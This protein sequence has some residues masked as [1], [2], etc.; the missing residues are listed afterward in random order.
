[1]KEP[2]ILDFPIPYY[3]QNK[4]HADAY[5]ELCFWYKEF[6]GKDAPEKYSEGNYLKIFEALNNKTLKNKKS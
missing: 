4:E 6:L 2:A 1:M 5:P 3:G